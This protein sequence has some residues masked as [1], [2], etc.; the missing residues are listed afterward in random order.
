M[1]QLFQSK[2]AVFHAFVN[3]P[4]RAADCAS[5]LC[6]QIRSAA[7]SAVPLH[8]YLRP[9]CLP[10][11]RCEG[12]EHFCELLSSATGKQPRDTTLQG[13]VVQVSSVFRAAHAVLRHCQACGYASE[14]CVRGSSLTLVQSGSPAHAQH[15]AAALQAHRGRARGRRGLRGRGVP[16]WGGPAARTAGLGAAPCARGPGGPPGPARHDGDR[17]PLAGPRPVR[18]RP[19][20][21][22]AAWQLR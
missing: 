5:Y 8:V 20:R 3:A 2:P 10:H 12:S 11:G 9:R 21:P 1:V 6:T 17:V 22:P 4:G 18:H 15:R 16:M 14:R 19:C 13:R 7:A